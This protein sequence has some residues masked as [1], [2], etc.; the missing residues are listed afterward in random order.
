M[1]ALIAL[2]FTMTALLPRAVAQEALPPEAHAAHEAIEEVTIS[3][4]RA[5]PGLWKI[6]K[7]D[8]TLYLFGTISRPPKKGATESNAMEQRVHTPI[9]VGAWFL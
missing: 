4:E 3:G 6:R 1:R 7:G 8:H 2:A 5:G 9:K